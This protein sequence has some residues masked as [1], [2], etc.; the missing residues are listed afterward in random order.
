MIKPGSEACSPPDPTSLKHVRIIENVMKPPC[1]TPD[2]HLHTYSTPSKPPAQPVIR[3]DREETPAPLKPPSTPAVVVTE[4]PCSTP[5]NCLTP[6]NSSTLKPAEESGTVRGGVEGEGGVVPSPDTSGTQTDSDNLAHSED[7][8]TEQSGMQR[9][10]GTKKTEDYDSGISSPSSSSPP[11]DSID[12]KI[13]VKK[14]R[15]KR[16]RGT[17]LAG[18]S[19][20]DCYERTG[21]IL[22]AGAFSQVELC[23]CIRT[24]HEFAVKV[25]KKDTWYNGYTRA[26]VHQE[27]E[28]LYRCTGHPNIVQLQDFYEGKEEFYLVFEMMRGGAL[29]DHIEKRKTFNERQAS[30]V[31][32]CITSALQHLHSAGIAHR[33]LKFDNLLCNDPEDFTRVKICDFDLGGQKLDIPYLSTPLL[34][35]PV[36]SAEFMA[37]EVVDLFVGHK[38]T[39]DKRCDMWSLGITLYIMLFGRPPFTGR[40]GLNCGWDDGEACAV[41]Q[42]LLFQSITSGRIT[43]PSESSVSDSAKDLIKKLLVKDARKRYTASEVLAHPWVTGKGNDNVLETPANLRRNTLSA[44]NLGNF[45]AKANEHYR[46]LNS[47]LNGLTEALDNLNL[48]QQLE[49]EAEKKKEE[50]ESTPELTP[51]TEKADFFISDEDDWYNIT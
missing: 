15:R 29:I 5:T 38:S 2:N 4:E 48:A 43:F 18:A 39:Y 42:E 34:D 44:T 12:I 46:Y 51:T 31:L 37:P 22:G 6:T 21:R 41:C 47:G 8:S 9:K 20:E 10:K 16:R 27:V 11:D 7:K 25:I 13:A 23:R 36:G 35:S 49:L 45:A 33:D 50:E 19:F 14:R 24:G 26:R 28:I 17:T 30:T 1:T 32:Y 3:P 40:C